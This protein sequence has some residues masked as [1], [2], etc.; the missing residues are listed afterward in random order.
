MYAN[1]IIIIVHKYFF[2]FK[3]IKVAFAKQ[4]RISR[5]YFS[6]LLRQ[7]YAE[8]EQGGPDGIVWKD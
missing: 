3:G 2:N 7:R 5:S 6:K 1:E 8:A 4:F